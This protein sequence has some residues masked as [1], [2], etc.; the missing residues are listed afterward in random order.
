[1]QMA[2]AATQLRDIAGPK[3]TVRN[4]AGVVDWLGELNSHGISNP[5][6]LAHFIAQIAHESDRFKTTTEYASGAAY[7]GRGDLG[8]TQSGDGKR[9]KGRGLI[10]CTG[11]YN[12]TKFNDWVRREFAHLNPPNF[13]TNPE[14]LSDFPWAMLSAVWYWQVGN[15]TRKSLNVYADRNDIEM[16]TRRINGGLN[17]YSDRLSLYTRTAL[18]LLGY[19]MVA[20]VIAKFQKDRG[21]LVDD[22]SGP[23]T[24]QA[25][26]DALTS[27]G[28]TVVPPPLIIQ[29]PPPPDIEPIPTDPDPPEWVGQSLNPPPLRRFFSALWNA[30][31]GF[32]KSSLK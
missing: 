8:N 2:L 15:P 21:L 14:K 12:Y 26:H 23:R 4:T 25:L 31:K 16:I 27:L 5:H 30:L 3:A 20:G 24:R 19:A 7:E 9:F 13:V 1:M 10:Q 11:R 22:I 6:R 32:F 28:G 17:G 18:V 29:P